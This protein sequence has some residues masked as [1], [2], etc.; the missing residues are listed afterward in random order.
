[1]LLALCAVLFVLMAAV[2]VKAEPPPVI[3]DEIIVQG[4]RDAT[5]SFQQQWEYH[6]QEYDRLRKLFGPPDIV[7]SR[8]GRLT[9]T[10]NPDAGKSVIPS[11]GSQ[12][13][14]GRPAPVP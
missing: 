8:L 7:N 9:D 1:M 5:P 10:P 13:V 3:A 4:R 12:I 14:Q 2:A 11:P 6:R